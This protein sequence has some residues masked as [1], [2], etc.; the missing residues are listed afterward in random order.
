M[1][2]VLLAVVI[3]C[4]VVFAALATSRRTPASNDSVADFQRHLSALSPEARRHTVENYPVVTSST[5]E[6]EEL[7]DG[8]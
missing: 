8:A 2:Y 6:T 7:D 5:E 3:V 4:V 1:V